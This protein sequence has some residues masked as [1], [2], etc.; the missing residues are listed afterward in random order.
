MILQI[1]KIMPK[2]DDKLRRSHK[3]SNVESASS[4]H[5]R[6]RL[7][8]LYKPDPATEAVSINWM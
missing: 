3:R 4:L 6:P 2:V 5:K 7:E 1:A 8:A